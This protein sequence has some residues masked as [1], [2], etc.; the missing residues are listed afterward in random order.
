MITFVI[1]QI[2]NETDQQFMLGIY[3]TYKP[4][5]FKTAR[6]YVSNY[7]AVEDL[8][9]DS[10]L[11]LIPKIPTL[12]QLQG[13]TL[14]TY[15]VYTVRNTAFNYLRKEA[16]EKRYLTFDDVDDLVHQLRTDDRF[17]E[18]SAERLELKVQ[19]M[20][21]L[22]KLPERDQ[23]VLIRKYYLS[24]SDQEIS[25]NLGC[26]PNSVRMMLTRIRRR[27]FSIMNEEGITYEVT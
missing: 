4:I 7:F 27:V 12:R 11:K 13:S 21:I 3:E 15:I 18:E 16:T 1:A 24:Q 10:L 2:D 22:R 17:I 6:K 8:V 9:Q 14:D 23:E 19:V 26:K 25:T 20:N 5:M